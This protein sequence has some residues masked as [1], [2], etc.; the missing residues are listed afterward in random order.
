MLRWGG[1]NRLVKNIRSRLD[2]TSN[3]QNQRKRCF[4]MCALF[5][6]RFPHFGV[7]VEIFA[8]AR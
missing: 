4:A 1:A 8:D 2:Q 3:E 7:R 5:L 6:F